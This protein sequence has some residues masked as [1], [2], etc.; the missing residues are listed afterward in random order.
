MPPS[1]TFD[2]S[3]YS[4]VTHQLYWHNNNSSPNTLINC[5]STL[6]PFCIFF[7][8]LQYISEIIKWFSITSPPE[9]AVFISYPCKVEPAMN[10]S[11]LQETLTQCTQHQVVMYPNMEIQ[12][13]KKKSKNIKFLLHYKCD[14]FSV[15]NVMTWLLEIDFVYSICSTHLAAS[16]PPCTSM[17]LLDGLAVGG[18]L[19]CMTSPLWKNV[20]LLIANTDSTAM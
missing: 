15:R 5:K 12:G 9:S 18:Q 20:T 10:L 6:E 13:F 17:S 8:P 1:S 2:S 11:C 4:S 19:V 3:H 14:T 7:Y 16:C